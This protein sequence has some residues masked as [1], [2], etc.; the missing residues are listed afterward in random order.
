MKRL[1]TESQEIQQLMALAARAETARMSPSRRTRVL[2][3]ARQ[4][5]TVWPTW[6]GASLAAAALL[7]ILTAPALLL[8]HPAGGQA[9]QRDLNLEV[10]L[11]ADGSVVLQWENGQSVH[12]VRRGTSARD[13]AK[14]NGIEV[15]GHRYQDASRSAAEIVY[16]QVD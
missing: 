15:A 3:A 1:E 4:P 6:A 5:H 8:Q 7:V 16:Y 14:V 11:G 9:P 10:S 2:A 13:L 12:T